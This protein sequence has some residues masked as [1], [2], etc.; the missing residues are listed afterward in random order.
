MTELLEFA[1]LMC[2]TGDP[3]LSQKV[4]KL[5]S[6]CQ[7]RGAEAMVGWTE[8]PTGIAQEEKRERKTL[9]Q[10]RLFQLCYLFYPHYDSSVIL[11]PLRKLAII[12]VYL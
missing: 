7:E 6:S 4:Q 10:I 12:F 9:F 3:G 1:S 11:L 8:A 2:F 5:N